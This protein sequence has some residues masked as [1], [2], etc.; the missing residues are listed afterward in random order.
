MTRNKAYP[1]WNSSDGSRGTMLS[2]KS[3]SQWLRLYG[4]K[5]TQGGHGKIMKMEEGLVAAGGVGRD[6]AGREG[7]EEA[8]GIFLW[9]LPESTECDDV[10]QT[11]QHTL[12][13][14]MAELP[15]RQGILSIIW[16]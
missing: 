8:R 4:C 5:Y 7:T 3:Q 15:V 14:K 13:G 16:L 9:W 11:F 6:G 12:M 10:A 2:E 1:P